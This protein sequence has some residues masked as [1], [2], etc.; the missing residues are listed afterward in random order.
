MRK[1]TTFMKAISVIFALVAV[2]AVAADSPAEL[3]EWLSPFPQA[4]GQTRIGSAPT[5]DSSYTAP[6]PPTV[7]VL[8]YQGQLRRAKIAFRT[9]FD[10][11][12]NTIVASAE[13]I[14]CVIHIGGTDSSARVEVKCGRI[15]QVAVTAASPVHS[16]L[17]PA[18]MRTPDWLRAFP[19]SRNQARTAAVGLDETVYTAIA[20]PAEVITHY[21][22]QL[23]Q[24]SVAF[25]TE[26]DG[27]ETAIWFPSQKPY[28]VVRVSPEYIGEG[29]H[30]RVGCG[31]EVADDSVKTRLSPSPRIVTKSEY[32]FLQAGMSYL[33]V[34]RIIGFRG[35]D[36][37]QSE[38]AGIS[39]VMYAWKNSNGS[40][41]NAVFQDGALVSKAQFGLP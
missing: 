25:R 24:V 28:C 18:I 20:Y 38:L 3:P 40:N 16:D 6:A 4:Q 33:Q 12:E 22:S 5:L 17:G 8:H 23:Q 11:V 21:Q 31:A 9:N 36:L 13:G 27:I 32:D 1:K 30:V 35:E 37:G 15:P 29:S 2:Q 26:S 7:V 41:M 19:K 34:I 10:G 39:T 14:F